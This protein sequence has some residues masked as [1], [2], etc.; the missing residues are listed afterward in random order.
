MGHLWEQRDEAVV[1]ASV[2]EVWQAIATGPGIDS[3][4][5]GRSEVEPGPSGSVRTD[6][7]GFVMD[8]AVTAWDPPHRFAYRGDGPGERFIA[9]EYLIEGREQSS[10]VLRVVASGFL[11]GDDWEAEFDA[12]TKGGAMY[13]RTLVAYLDHFPGRAG[14]PINL[15]GPPVTDWAAA[16]TA[17]RGELGLSARPSLGDPVRVTLPGLPPI[18]GVVDF[19]NPAAIGVRTA[20]AL[21]RFIQGFFGS[22]T[23]G[24]HLFADAVDEQQLTQAWHAWVNGLTA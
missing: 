20:D 13:F 22:V 16:W 1:E 17:L 4:F 23:L 21:Y 3:W 2:E 12:M 7:G 18:D 15:A 11:P 14:I 19:V 8:S 9:Y 24:H 5:M 10:T 6:L